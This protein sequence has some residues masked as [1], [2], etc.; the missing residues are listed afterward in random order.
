[1]AWSS[2][3]VVTVFSTDHAAG[4]S[5]PDD[6]R[7]ECCLHNT[8]GGFRSCY[9]LH[10]RSGGFDMKVVRI[11]FAA[12]SVAL[13]AFSTSVR[14]DGVPRPYSAPVVLTST[15]WS[16]FYIGA[17]AGGAWGDFGLRNVSAERFS[18]FRS[19]SWG[20]D[21]LQRRGK[22]GHDTSFTGGLQIGYE[23]ANQLVISCTMGSRPMSIGCP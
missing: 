20:S 2:L 10:L 17:N 9:R 1:M 11:F 4:H 7:W 6:L 22:S 3:S 15:N 19:G 21:Q 12:V 14:A 5:L 8:A 16:G 23:R 18:V 13:V